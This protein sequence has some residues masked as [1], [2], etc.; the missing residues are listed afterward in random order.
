MIV[1]NH[2]TNKLFYRNLRLLK[3]SSEEVK[4]NGDDVNYLLVFLE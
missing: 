2:S 3:V 4:R 1:A